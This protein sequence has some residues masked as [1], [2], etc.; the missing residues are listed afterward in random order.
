MVVTAMVSNGRSRRR[1]RRR[2]QANVD[3]DRIGIDRRLMRDVVGVPQEELQSVTSRRQGD[4]RLRLA[5]SEM[6]VVLVVRD[7]LV[8]RGERRVNQQVVVAGV[9]LVDT[10]WSHPHFLESEPNRERGWHISA[11]LRRNNIFAGSR[12]RRMAGPR[13]G[14]RRRDSCRRRAFN[15]HD[16]NL[17]G[18]DGGRMRDVVLIAEQQL[19]CV[20]PR[21]QR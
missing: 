21:R 13:L 5:A 14:G 4:V 9:R 1:R 6:Q 10:G 19:Q 18:I 11:V 3:D 16:V 8:Q 17:V 2:G 15:H 12:R 20:R 7:R